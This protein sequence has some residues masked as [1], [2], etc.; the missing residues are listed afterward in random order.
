MR[1]L[2]RALVSRPPGG[3]TAA[4]GDDPRTGNVPVGSRRPP[5]PGDSPDP[6]DRIGRFRSSLPPVA[7]A[8]AASGRV[9]AP[10]DDARLRGIPATEIFPTPPPFDDGATDPPPGV[11]A[12]SSDRSRSPSR[13]PS[14]FPPARPSARRSGGEPASIRATV[15]IPRHRALGRRPRTRNLDPEGDSP[16]PAPPPPRP[17]PGAPGP[18]PGPILPFP[19]PSGALNA[20]KAARR[21][22]R[23]KGAPT[24]SRRFPPPR[25]IATGWVRRPGRRGDGDPPGRALRRWIPLLGAALPAGRPEMRLPFPAPTMGVDRRGIRSHRPPGHRVTPSPGSPSVA[26]AP[27][28]S[29]SPSAPPPR[30]F[31][32]G[33]FLRSMQGAAGRRPA[34]RPPRRGPLPTGAG[35][36]PRGRPA[37]PAP[38]DSLASDRADRPVRPSHREVRRGRGARRRPGS[39][40]GSGPGA[41]RPGR[42]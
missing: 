2:N 32:P 19:A 24:D 27:A 34:G 39:P 13:P 25:P 12:R 17:G 40:G 33:A 26:A 1:P 31:L 3:G 8:A 41:A 11:G 14:A 22:R 4:T 36:R 35:P 28:R 20:R 30:V 38:G 9:A 23:L 15:P 42:R 7:P 18:L 6:K 37:T 29:P 10:S 5:P 16:A 21:A